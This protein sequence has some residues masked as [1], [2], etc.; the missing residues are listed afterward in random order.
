[1]L[2]RQLGG[3]RGSRFTCWRP[4]CILAASKSRISLSVY[5]ADGRGGEDLWPVEFNLAA[6][7]EVRMRL[8]PA[9]HRDPHNNQGIE[10]NLKKIRKVN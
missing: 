8:K 1:M 4:W 7:I 10:I 5:A 9:E 2:P 6:R 3:F